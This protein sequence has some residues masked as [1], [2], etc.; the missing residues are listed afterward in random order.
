M[1]YFWKVGFHNRLTWPLKWFYVTNC[2]NGTTSGL[3]FKSV[4]VF[5]WKL[6]QWTKVNRQLCSNRRNWVYS[7]SENVKHSVIRPERCGLPTEVEVLVLIACYSGHSC[8]TPAFSCLVCAIFLIS[9]NLQFF[10]FRPDLYIS[11]C[12]G[13]RG[14]HFHCFVESI[15][16]KKRGLKSYSENGVLLD[17]II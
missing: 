17:I 13:M 4:L 6:T 2:T 16:C 5:L 9:Y 7:P 1:S 14:S 3:V 11:S 8:E 15:K 10:G 12:V